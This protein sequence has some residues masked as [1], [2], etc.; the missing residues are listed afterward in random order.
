MIGDWDAPIPWHFETPSGTLDLNTADGYRFLLVSSGCDGGVDLRIT[1]DNVPQGNGEIPHKAFTSGYK[2]R[3]LLELREAIDPTSPQ[4]EARGACGRDLTDMLDQLGLHIN[5]I[6]NAVPDGSGTFQRL[7]WAPDGLPERMLDKI[8]LLE[9]PVV[10][11]DG[12][13][14]P[15]VAFAVFSEFPYYL[16]HADTT[17]AF[18]DGET[19]TLANGGT[20]DYYPVF[21]VAGPTSAFTITNN[22][23]LDADGN[24]LE[25]VYD[26][27]LP[28]AVAIPSGHTVEINTFK[29]TAYLDGNVASRIAG[30]DIQA[31]D[32]FQ[33]P[34]P[35]A[36]ITISGAAMN[37]ITADAW[38]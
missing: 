1:E 35:G 5:E 15:R 21:E 26:S 27:T 18:S 24:P 28:G 13:N 32:F 17:T 8:R 37:A 33:I 14:P 9:R 16:S 25:I 23:V 2:I 38:R 36:S 12:A 6:L 22:S 34:P 20:C 30:I 11:Q 7:W 10:T 19:A 3:L 29:N 4:A 31:S